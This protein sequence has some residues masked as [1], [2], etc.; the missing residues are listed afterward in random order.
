DQSIDWGWGD[1]RIIGLLALFVVL[2]ISFVFVERKADQHALVPPDVIR[3]RDFAFTCLAILLMSAVFFAAMLYLPQLM[4]NVLGYSPI[5]AGAGMLPM[6]VTFAAVS[7]IA[8]PLYE[9][10]GGRI[11]LI[12]GSA[13]LALGPALIALFA[14]KES[15]G[16]LLP[17]LV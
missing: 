7:F 3:N 14:D 8:G 16:A 12:V 11:L 17:G 6:M 2:M 5:G 10:V 15:L 13:C 1:P 9:R 4:I